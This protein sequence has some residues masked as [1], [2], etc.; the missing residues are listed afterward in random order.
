MAFVPPSI[1][2]LFSQWEQMGIFTLVLPFLLIFAIVYAILN[3]SKI[4]GENKGVQSVIALAVGL[5][6]II[7]P[8][9]TNFFQMI[10]PRL[11]IGISVLLVVIILIGLFAGG[12][13]TSIN[14]TIMWILFGVGGFI[15]LIIV[16]STFSDLGWFASYMDWQQAIPTLIAVGVIITLVVLIIKGK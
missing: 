5:L 15:A 1:S 13:N 11:G 14:T 2:E 3:K 8:T 12:T 9:V 16:F 4:L 7:N 10:F 6:A